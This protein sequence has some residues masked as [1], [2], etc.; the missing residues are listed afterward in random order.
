MSLLAIKEPF[1]SS[2]AF[3]ATC[4]TVMYFSEHLVGSMA[5]LTL[6]SSGNDKSVMSHHFPG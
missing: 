6:S 3:F 2:T 1:P 4:S 5:S